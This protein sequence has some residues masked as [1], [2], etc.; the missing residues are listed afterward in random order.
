MMPALNFRMVIIQISTTFLRWAL[1]LPRL[2][3]R[4]RTA[5]SW[6]LRTSFTAKWQRRSLP[7]TCLPLPVPH[8]GC[9]SS[10]GSRLSRQKLRKVAYQRLLHVCVL[11]INYMYLGRFP[12]LAEL[13]RSPNPWQLRC[14]QRLRALLH[15]SGSAKAEEGGIPATFTCLCFG[16]QLH[17]PR[18]VS[19]VG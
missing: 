16:D 6:C 19:Y 10:S 2:I 3:L 14:F 18:Q 1:S 5:F 12:T 11:V 7:T 9:F 4:C 17:V 15:V 13:G 8:P